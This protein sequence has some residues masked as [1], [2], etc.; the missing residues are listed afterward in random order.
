MCNQTISFEK[1]ISILGGKNES[2]WG[3]STED[4]KHVFLFSNFYESYLHIFLLLM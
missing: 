3:Q 2:L 4:E 1:M